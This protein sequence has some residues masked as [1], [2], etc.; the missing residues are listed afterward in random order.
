MNIVEIII[1]VLVV[2]SGLSFAGLL[3][4]WSYQMAVEAKNEK[5]LAIK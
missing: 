3:F 2:S 1:S 4:Y 5:K